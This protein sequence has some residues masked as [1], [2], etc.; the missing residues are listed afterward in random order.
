MLPRE[1][2]MQALHDSVTDPR[3]RRKA[4]EACAT[5]LLD[6]APCDPA[7]QHSVAMYLNDEAYAI[8]PD[9]CPLCYGNVSA[10]DGDNGNAV[11]IDGVFA[12]HACVQRLVGAH[13]AAKS[14]PGKGD[15]P[16]PAP[17]GRSTIA[18]QDIAM[19][20]VWG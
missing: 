14:A 1:L 17:T 11:V 15:T 4:V 2:F 19:D 20:S 9:I 13:L 10:D 8:A 6:L 3:Q 5:L 18:E 16:T 7:L 12:H